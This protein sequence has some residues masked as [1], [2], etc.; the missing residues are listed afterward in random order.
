MTWRHDS[1]EEP[2]TTISCWLAASNE[3][4]ADAPAYIALVKQTLMNRE[5]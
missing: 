1:E 2:T 3:N 4:I 5:I